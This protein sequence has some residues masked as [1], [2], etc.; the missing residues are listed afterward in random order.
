[1]TAAGQ[2]GAPLP[3]PLQRVAEKLWKDESHV[4]INRNLYK[5]KFIVA[6]KI[7][8]DVE[9]YNSLEAGFFLWLK[10]N[11]GEDIARRLWTEVG[12]KTLPGKYLGREDKGLNPG[13]DF[14]RIALVAP[15]DEMSEGLK[16]INKCLFK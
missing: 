11:D 5:E 7:F 3:L 14:L 9:S 4:E 8:S 6:D 10:V 13:T 15:I 16:R 1:M 2:K 12:V